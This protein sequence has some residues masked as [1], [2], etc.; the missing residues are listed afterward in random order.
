MEPPP[1]LNY[2]VAL[3]SLHLNASMYTEPYLC[4]VYIE[5]FSSCL[6]FVVLK[7]HHKELPLPFWQHFRQSLCVC[8]CVCV[9]VCIYVCV[10]LLF[11]CLVMLGSVFLSLC[12]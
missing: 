11:L 5:Y 3:S 8:V 9:C 6:S 7:S 1:T 12:V 10:C 2:R 4:C